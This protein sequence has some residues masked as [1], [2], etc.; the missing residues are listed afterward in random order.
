MSTSNDWK[1]TVTQ[2]YRSSEV[3]EI[4][5]VLASLEPGATSESKLMLAMRFED[6][7]FSGAI[8]L[9][10]YRKKL[11]KRLKKLQKNYKPPVGVNNSASNLEHRLLSLKLKYGDSLAYIH[12]N[13]ALAVA[14]MK[15][16]SGSERAKLLQQHIDNARIWSNQ[17]GVLTVKDSKPATSSLTESEVDRLQS[18]LEQRIDNIRSHVV[19][20]IEPDLFLQERL[21]EL[22]SKRGDVA[23]SQALSTMLTQALKSQSE[24]SW[25]QHSDPVTTLNEY[26]DKIM[27][28][29]PPPSKDPSS[30]S[31]A[32]LSHL[33]ALRGASQVLL[34]YMMLSDPCAVEIPKNVL[35]KCHS[36]A[37][38]ATAFLKEELPSIVHIEDGNR[39]KTIVIEDLWNKVMELPPVYDDHDHDPLL[40]PRD[41][42]PP[43]K[44]LRSTA[45]RSQILLTPG[46][47]CP[48]NLLP[49]LKRKGAKLIQPSPSITY[50]NLNFEA[51]DMTIYFVPLV[52]EIQVNKAR[53]SDSLTNKVRSSHLQDRIAYAAARA[54][55]ILRTC[56]TRGITKAKTEF[57]IEISEATSLLHFLQLARATYTPDWKD[58][59]LE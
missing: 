38:Q 49:A 18:H 42:P 48:T 43:A 58:V 29:V 32:A 59:V 27:S 13:S 12:K 16:R 53:I 54:T 50:L 19:K 24:D 35:C 10:D 44:K 3:R 46:R 20:L 47:P 55:H 30:K 22:E 41:G 23:A 6:T 56:F 15:E 28:I 1:T 45:I 57:E 8:S 2:A 17:L 40:N 7:I 21:E 37:G 11:A 51:F 31:K 33:E 34:M 36:R 4:A 5:Q 25:I 39:P 9:A 14:V 26:L 52:V